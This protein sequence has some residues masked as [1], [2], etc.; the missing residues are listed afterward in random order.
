MSI[1]FGKSNPALRLENRLSSA[2]ILPVVVLLLSA[3]GGGS[4][5]PSI[6]DPKLAPEIKSSASAML[7]AP[8]LAQTSSGLEKIGLRWSKS[9]NATGLSKASLLITSPVFRFYNSMTGTHF[10][11]INES[12]RNEILLDSSKDFLQ[13]EGPAFSAA[14]S[15]NA[16][17][18]LSPVFRFYNRLNGVHFYTI[19]EDERD[20][21]QNDPALKS[22][23][24]EG[25][26]YYA[27]KKDGAGKKP[28]YRFF[29]ISKGTHFY[30]ASAS[31]RDRIQREISAD[32]FYEGVAYHVLEPDVGLVNAQTPHSGATENQCYTAGSDV[33]VACSSVGAVTLSSKQDGHRLGVRPMSFSVVPG[34]PLTECVRDNVTGLVW[35]GKEASGYFGGG[36]T[37]TSLNDGEINDAFTYVLV[38]NYYATCGYYDWRLPTRAE[39]LTIMNY[40]ASAPKLNASWFPNTEGV[41]FGN[42]LAS[43]SNSAMAGNTWTVRP[44]GLSLRGGE[45]N[46]FL[47]KVRLVRGKQR[48][49]NRFSVGTA[50]YAGDMAD[51]MVT[52]SWTG[53]Q[54]RR[55]L[56]GQAWNGTT[57][58]GNT[59][60]YDYETALNNAEAT[61]G[62]RVPNV[63]ELNSLVVLA[64]QSPPLFDTTAFPNAQEL[65]NWS[66]TP[67]IEDP[68]FAVYVDFLGGEVGFG[69]R[70]G[71]A[72]IR[73]VRDV[74]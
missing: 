23:S 41:G 9:T 33:L 4:T 6:S 74:P 64:K 43:E 59:I 8:E 63:K 51:N 42:Y 35:E 13:Y 5:D 54:W 21:I 3:C 15:S 11:S 14:Q 16:A 71:G 48:A 37:F 52:D 29:V 66:S 55:C 58:L 49:G 47:K 36:Q 53:L 34:R 31:E 28:L 25:I 44:D 61:P 70:G 18:D 20:S 24:Y 73:L 2:G 27:S 60:R 67:H 68:H 46:T 72:A 38:A 17:P 10:Y 1:F 50:P 57:C 62:W 26:A 65:W 22:F 12:E 40:G 30:T 19:N 69:G 45:P 56:E 7:I 32:F 39:L